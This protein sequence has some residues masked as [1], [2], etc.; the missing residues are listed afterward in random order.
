MA[1]G[2]KHRFGKTELSELLYLLSKLVVENKIEFTKIEQYLPKE[3]EEVL[4]LCENKMIFHGEYLLGNW[5]MYSP[6]YSSKIISN[7]CPFRVIG[8]VG[9]NNFIF[10]QL[11]ELIMLVQLMEAKV[12]YV[13]I[14]ERGKQKRVTEKYLVNA[15]SCTECEKLMNEELSI[16]QAEEFSVLAVGRTNF[17]EFLGDKDKE[18][19]KLF[20][21]K[22]NYITLNDDGDEKKTP[23]MLIVEADTTEEA[24]NTVKEAM[25]ASMADWRI[26]RVVESNYVDIVNL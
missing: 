2:E 13:K 6:E 23:C 1:Q 8:W 10:N 5:F 11:K 17:Q 3:G 26:E 9:I 16:Y 15:M 4:F 7:I 20:M 18:D 22:L 14:N 24:T 19:K 25:S 21:V 12:S